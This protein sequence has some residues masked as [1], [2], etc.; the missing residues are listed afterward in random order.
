MEASW[1][2]NTDTY[3]EKRNFDVPAKEVDIETPFENVKETVE[4]VKQTHEKVQKIRVEHLNAWLKKDDEP[5]KDHA[6]LSVEEPPPHQKL[7][8]EE[9]AMQFASSAS[10]QDEQSDHE[11]PGPYRKEGQR[12]ASDKDTSVDDL[13]SEQN[14]VRAADTTALTQDEQHNEGLDKFL[15]KETP[16]RDEIFDGCLASVRDIPNSIRHKQILK[17][18][19]L[20][21]SHLKWFMQEL[22]NQGGIL[23]I[24]RVRSIFMLPAVYR[25]NANMLLRIYTHDKLN[26][27]TARGQ[28][29]EFDDK[30]MYAN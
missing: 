6:C 29:L 30:M 8:N 10:L 23:D 18:L 19:P 25:S 20:A 11:C 21:K 28:Q 24:N 2:F 5:D 9:L 22:L 3:M 27:I 17:L 7:T 1:D 4:I 13:L 26:A 15:N 12:S 16:T 14:P